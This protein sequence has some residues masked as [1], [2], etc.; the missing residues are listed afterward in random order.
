M[1]DIPS[2]RKDNSPLQLEGRKKR[3]IKNRKEK[4]E[5]N[6]PCDRVGD[7]PTRGRPG[8]KGS[9]IAT[10][11]DQENEEKKEKKKERK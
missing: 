11:G 7:G 10:G 9:C 8:S 6:A 3:K 5:E 1:S 2:K 4:P